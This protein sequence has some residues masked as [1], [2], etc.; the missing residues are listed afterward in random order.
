MPLPAFEQAVILTN[1]APPLTALLLG[2]ALIDSTEDLNRLSQR[3]VVWLRT[4]R[5]VL[6]Q[7]AAIPAAV[8]LSAAVD[9][10]LYATVPLFV[11]AAAVLVV[12]LGDWYWPPILIGIYGWL[13]FTQAEAFLTAVDVGPILLAGA[14]LLGGVAY[15]F[16]ERLRSQL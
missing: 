8:T 10:A 12:L 3:P 5:Y 7:I 15:V 13:R 9:S 4:A 2:H 11:A 14:V 16:G 1:L 6:I